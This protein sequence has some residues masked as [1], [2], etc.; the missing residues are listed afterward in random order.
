M[1]ARHQDARLRRVL[2]Q[3]NPVSKYWWKCLTASLCAIAYRL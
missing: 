2:G 1:A 3:G